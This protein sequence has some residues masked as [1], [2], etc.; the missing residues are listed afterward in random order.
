VLY[1]TL[2]PR[3]WV[4]EDRVWLAD[5]VPGDSGYAVPSP[6]DPVAPS[7]VDDEVVTHAVVDPS[8]VP[9]QMEALRAHATQV[10]VGNGWFALSNDVVSRLPGREGYARLDP[11]S[12]T[13]AAADGPV[14]RGLLE[15]DA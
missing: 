14:R 15:A 4:A 11:R 3:S 10:V 1:V 8:V 7:V 12:G 2:T 6:T 5:H 9:R 13:L